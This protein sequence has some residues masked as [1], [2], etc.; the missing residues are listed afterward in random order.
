[1]KQPAAGAIACEKELANQE[2]LGLRTSEKLQFSA[3]QK[4]PV[5][6]IL[7]RGRLTVPFAGIFPI[8]DLVIHL[9]EK[10]AFR[11]NDPFGVPI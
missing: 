9:D 6:S 3:L 8:T 5:L 2:S 7:N 11:I 4:R 1:M 10:H